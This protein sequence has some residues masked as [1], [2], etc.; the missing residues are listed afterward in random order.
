M[1]LTVVVRVRGK[2]HKHPC[3]DLD[4]ALAVL[5]RELRATATAVGRT[6]D[7]TVLGRDYGPEAQVVVRGELRGGP[8]HA[9]ID[10]RGDGSAQ[11][12]TGR[13]RKQPVA[14]QGREDAYRALRRAL[15]A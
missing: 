4:E 15:G 8:R 2:V 13:V 10:V 1:A 9:G 11:A 5:E 12:W 6:G 14:P 3:P 7:T